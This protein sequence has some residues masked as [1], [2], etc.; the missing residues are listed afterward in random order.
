MIPLEESD[1]SSWYDEQLRLASTIGQHGFCFYAKGI[2]SVESKEGCVKVDL[3][4][5]MLAN[6]ASMMA[7]GKL[8]G[9]GMRTS[10]TSYAGRNSERTL[11]NVTRYL[12]QL[13]CC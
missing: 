9:Q 5:E 7:L 11:P 1:A 3:A 4:S 2:S 12:A 8:I 10:K 6:T 13:P